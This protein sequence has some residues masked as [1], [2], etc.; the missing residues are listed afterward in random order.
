M[1]K[2]KRILWGIV[3]VA[4]GVLLVLNTLEIIKFDPFF[5]GFWTLFIIIPCGIGLITDRN[6]IGSLVGLT[7]GVALLLAARDVITYDLIWKLCLPFAVIFIGLGVIFKAFG[8]KETREVEKK[9]RENGEPL[10]EYCATFTG[11]NVDFTGREFKGASVSAIFGGVKLDLSRASINGD[12]VIKTSSIFGGV[13][14]IL[15]DDVNVKLSSSSVFGGV[16]DKREKK[17]IDGAHTLYISANC[18]FGGCDIK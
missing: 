5:R 13:D 8:R 9:L 10:E 18:I 17:N 14:I 6:K 7:F 12:V 11:S 16:S 3:L 2:V 4:I 1:N 15:P